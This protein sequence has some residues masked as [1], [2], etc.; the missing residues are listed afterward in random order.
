MTK[1]DAS[2]S[3]DLD[4]PLDGDVPDG[5]RVEEVPVL[6]H[7]VG[8]VARQVHVVVDVVRAAARGEG[9]LE[10]RRPAVPRPEV[11]GA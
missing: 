10:E 5:D 3:G 4:D 1:A 8:V 6:L 2:G 11:E 7:R 9:L